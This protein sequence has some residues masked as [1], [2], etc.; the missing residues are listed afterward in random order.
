MSL[1]EDVEP[2]APPARAKVFYSA[3]DG[4]RGLA[5]FGV[6]FFHL[7]NWTDTHNFF[8]RGDLAVDFFFC[9]SGFVL[10][11]AYSKRIGKTMGFSKFAVTRII[12]LYPMLALS[13]LVAAT[14]F[15]GK[16]L[17]SSDQIPIS[18]IAAS[19]GTA[20]L[21]LP[22][23]GSSVPLSGPYEAFP[24]NGPLWSLFYEFFIGFVW[25]AAFAFLTFRKTIAFAVIC[26]AILLFGGIL[27]ND[28]LLGDR[29]TDFLWGF[30][31]VGVTF[32]L[33]LLV[34]HV[35]TQKM[36]RL[37]L[38]L[39]AICL[40]LIAPLTVARGTGL[41]A[42]FFDAGFVYILTPAIILMG[43][44]IQLSGAIKKASDIGGELSYPIYVMH[45][46]LF[47]WMNGA[48]HMSGLSLPIWV[49]LL[50]HFVVITA[51]SWLAL[52]WFD[53]PVRRLLTQYQKKQR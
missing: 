45:F 47:A 3:L 37:R 41:S 30:P 27:H 15:L 13:V 8:P 2:S 26:A 29:T 24:V 35:H 28:L 20:L 49:T 33:G 22:Y 16:S 44:E 52:V 7:A 43:A 38:P 36:L 48:V 4:L 5:A 21:V 40:L 23:F 6:V 19:A 18:D 32:A 11:H 10:A 51:G 12:R 34:H 53:R 46:P 50:I 25:A 9:L 14:F 31:R 39:W 42:V 17:L 1:I